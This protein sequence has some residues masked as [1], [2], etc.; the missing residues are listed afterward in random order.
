MDNHSGENYFYRQF[1]WI[2]SSTQ[3][4]SYFR[5][6]EMQDHFSSMCPLPRTPGTQ[7]GKGGYILLV[8]YDFRH[9]G[10]LGRKQTSRGR[11]RE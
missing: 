7:P 4:D 6:P 2:S 5:N 3:L 9:K 11:S 10:L 1:E 8:S